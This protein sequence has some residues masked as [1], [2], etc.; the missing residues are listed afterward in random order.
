MKARW[1]WKQLKY[2]QG[3]LLMDT[4]VDMKAMLK[5]KTD[6]ILSRASSQSKVST[7]LRLSLYFT[8][9]TVGI[10]FSFSPNQLIK[11]TSG[12]KLPQTHV[13]HLE[14][15]Q[16]GRSST[17]RSFLFYSCLRNKDIVFMTHTRF[18]SYQLKYHPRSKSAALMQLR[19]RLKLRWG[20]CS[21]C[22][23]TFS[24]KVFSF[25][26]SFFPFRVNFS[27]YNS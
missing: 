27:V 6:R 11:N 13:S 24:T 9:Q 16:G 8:F 1:K 25:V 18:R 10:E 14:S 19:N 4:I 15:S 20:R 7:L 5:M 26:I 3:H 12:V 21:W 2:S 22:S 17:F 23:P